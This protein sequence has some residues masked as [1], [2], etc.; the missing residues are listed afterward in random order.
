MTIEIPQYKHL[1]ENQFLE[2]VDNKSY[3][4][5]GENGSGKSTILE[6]VFKKY[7]EDDEKNVI[8]FTSGQN[9]LY[10]DIFNTHKRN[11]SRFSQNENNVIKSYFFDKDWI[12]LLIFYSTSLKSNGLVR[13][14]LLNKGII[15]VD[16][17]TN[18]DISTKLSFKF[19]VNKEYIDV[20]KNELLVEGRGEFVENSKRRTKQF[21]LLQRLINHKINSNYDFDEI[22]DT[23]TKRTIEINSDE[24][25]VIFNSDTNSIFTFLSHS[26]LDRLSNIDIKS[27][28]LYFDNSLEFNQLSDGEYQLLSIYSLIDLFDSDNTIFLFDEIDSHLHYKNIQLLWNTLNNINGKVLTTSHIVDS[29][30]VNDFDTI[31]LID[32][33]NIQQNTPIEKVFDRLNTITSNDTYKFKVSSKLDNIVLVENYTDWF[34]FRELCII[35]MDSGY[36]EDVFNGIHYINCSSGYEN[37]TEVFGNNKLNWYKKYKEVISRS[38]SKVK[39]I[40]MICDRDDLSIGSIK[41]NL[42]VT[43]TEEHK[44][45]LKKHSRTTPHLLSWKRKQIENY[46]IS[47]SMLDY[48]G[49]TESILN[50]LERSF[51]LTNTNLDCIQIQSLEIKDELKVLYSDENGVDYLKLKEVIGKIPKEEISEDIKIMYGYIKSKVE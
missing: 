44:P 38:D 41:D 21:S 11:S 16:S 28:K 26:V 33:G 2:Y 22:S 29:I 1:P 10:S 14:F 7:I 43:E 39:N 18:N 51:E 31:K 49:M 36:N 23:I 45:I 13:K 25:D 24:V 15:E 19:G 5:I 4:L 3:L 12:R 47:K 20:I 35:K 30:I 32:D 34:I 42:I 50:K 9:E 17:F 27:V 6:S 46:L 40:F 8:C 48:Y 37:H